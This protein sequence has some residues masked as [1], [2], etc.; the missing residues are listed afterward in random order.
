MRGLVEWFYGLVRLD[1]SE[2]LPYRQKLLLFILTSVVSLWIVVTIIKDIAG[3]L[4]L[5]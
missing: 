3:R 1:D 2:D 5:D 4:I